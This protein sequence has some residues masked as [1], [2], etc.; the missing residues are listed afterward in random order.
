M[1]ST[2]SASNFFKTN[3]RFSA[4]T[5][6]HTKLETIDELSS[7]EDIERELKL[8]KDR[9]LKCGARELSEEYLA[10][11]KER[12]L[13]ESSPRTVGE[14]PYS[15][16]KNVSEIKSEYHRRSPTDM[17]RGFLE[18]APKDKLRCRL[19]TLEIETQP[20]PISPNPVS[21]LEL[22][23]YN[24]SK[25]VAYGVSVLRPSFISKYLGSLADVDASST[26]EDLGSSVASSLTDSYVSS[27]SYSDGD[28]SLFSVFGSF[29]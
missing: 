1:Y 5:K 11:L 20:V 8:E 7:I 9:L 22:N 24:P 23:A 26:N 6:K 2:S 27:S 25:K 14:L 15:P 19:G 28:P 12:K 16:T 10:L 13:L 3:N 29:K 18:Q 21:E 4:S 17:I